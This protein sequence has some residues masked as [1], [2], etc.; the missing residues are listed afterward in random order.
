MRE[1]SQGLKGSY[2]LVFLKLLSHHLTEPQLGEHHIHQIFESW[3][4]RSVGRLTNTMPD[5]FYLISPPL[6]A[7]SAWRLFILIVIRIITYPTFMNLF[8]VLITIAP[9]QWTPRFSASY[10]WSLHLYQL[11]NQGTSSSILC[12]RNHTC[13]V[14]WS[15]AFHFWICLN[16]IAIHSVNYAICFADMLLTESAI[17][18]KITSLLVACIC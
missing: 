11:C 17:L 2:P 4:W 3:G 1:A 9:M 13:R 6:T 8:F 10:W 18:R 16:D 7:S 12:N 14:L 5:I 15:M